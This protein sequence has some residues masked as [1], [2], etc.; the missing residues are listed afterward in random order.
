ML[1]TFFFK[2]PIDMSYFGLNFPSYPVNLSYL[3]LHFLSYH[4]DLSYLGLNFLSYPVDLSYPA[5][6]AKPN[7]RAVHGEWTALYGV[8]YMSS[9]LLN[10]L[11][12]ILNP[13]KITTAIS[14]S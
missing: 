7:R 1:L 13:L 10:R 3:G 2:K 6:G 8:L 5:M 14:D 11:D 4:V 12:E 9:S